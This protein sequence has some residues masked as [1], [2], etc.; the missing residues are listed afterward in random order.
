LIT[1]TYLIVVPMRFSETKA[2]HAAV[3]TG[4][5]GLTMVFWLAGFLALGAFAWYVIQLRDQILES[6]ADLCALPGSLLPSL[7]LLPLCTSFVSAVA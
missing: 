1:L 7:S 4:V 2:N 3:I 5:E 6:E